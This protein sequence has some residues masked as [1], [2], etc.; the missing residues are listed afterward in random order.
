MKWNHLVILC[1]LTLYSLVSTNKEVSR[2]PAAEDQTQYGWKET[3]VDEFNGREAAV[4]RGTPSTCFDMPPQC[5][6]NYWSQ[7]ECKPEY[8]AG[9]KNLNK[10]HWRV[11][12]MYNWMD[13]DAKEGQ[14]VNAFAPSQVEVK[15]GNL[16]LYASRSSFS[17]SQLDC[18]R[19]FYDPEISWEND[20]KKCPFIS[21]GINSKTHENNG[22]KVGFAQEYGRFEVRAILPDGPG[23]WPA[24]WLLPDIEPDQNSA[25]KGCGWPFSGE[26]DIME[27]WSDSDGKKYK[28]GLITGNCEQNI[29]SGEGGHGKSKTITTD[30]HKYIVEWTPNYVKFIFDEDVIHTVYK[31]NPI[32]SKYHQN[33]GTNY[34]ADELD[35]RFK[36]PARI[37]NHPFYWI[38]NTTIEHGLGKREKYRP[39]P[40]NFKT[41]KHV[42]DYVKTYARCTAS[43]DPA[44][45]VKF[46]DHDTVYNYNTNKNETA[47]VE[48]NV[49]P[50][51]QLKGRDMTTRIT[52]HQ[53][54]KNVTFTLVNMAGQI[55][56][57]N[58]SSGDDQSRGHLYKGPL[59]QGETK[60]IVFMTNNLAAGMYLAT[61]WFDGCGENGAGEG[62]HVFKMVVI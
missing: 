56:G 54:C 5:M 4:A 42:I 28:G 44:L 13:F 16:T 26:I 59:G 22:T 62:N 35:D 10:C 45:C 19:K 39:N 25:G 29:A 46:K 20:T 52:S 11:Y 37:P 36:H 57:V 27:M 53:Y 24:H 31:D 12:D 14:G 33:D 7:K 30:F 55:V 3:F 40:D 50:S 61:A 9:L 18:K 17:T 51:P 6:V 43:D 38:L 1:S 49:F 15:N 48:I 60:E 34:S 2:L 8:H 32:K 47:S 21:G 58:K 23:S 41:T